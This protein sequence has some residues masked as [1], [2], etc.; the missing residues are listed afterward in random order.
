MAGVKG[1]SGRAGRKSNAEEEYRFR[2][3]ERCWKIVNE[4]LDNEDLPLQFRVELASKH[5]VKHMPT[6]LT[7]LLG[8]RP[9]MMGYIEIN[10][11]KAEFDIGTR[12]ELE[13]DEPPITSP[14]ESSA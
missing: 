14:S 3:V 7:G 5:T 2:T 4:N 13:E 6:E 9:V 10:G 8:L 11:K 1:R 12:P